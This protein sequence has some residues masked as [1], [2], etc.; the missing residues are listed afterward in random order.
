MTAQ[1]APAG[2]QARR[3]IRYIDRALQKRLLTGFI[4]LEV[5]LVVAGLVYLHGS[6]EAVLEENLYRIHLADAEPIFSLLLRETALVLGGMLLANLA[7]LGGANWLWARYVDSI[8]QPFAGL[9]ERTAG[10]DLAEDVGIAPRHRVL[11]LALA[12]RAAE[13]TRCLRIRAAVSSL[14]DDTA[15]QTRTALERIKAELP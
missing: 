13:R 2:P 6:L 7:V 5:L 3:R 4:L 8:L 10:L 9:L 15:P 14:S 11:V 1:T 12:W